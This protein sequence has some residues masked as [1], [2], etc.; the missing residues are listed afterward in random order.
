MR[1]RRWTTVAARG[2]GHAAARHAQAITPT[3]SAASRIDIAPPSE[4]TAIPARRSR[5]IT[6][7]ASRAPSVAGSRARSIGEKSG[8]APL[9]RK[10]A[11]RWTTSA[12]GRR[13]ASADSVAPGPVNVTTCVGIARRQWP[14]LLVRASRHHGC[15]QAGA[16]SQSPPRRPLELRRCGDGRS[17]VRDCIRSGL[18]LVG[19][20][21]NRAVTEGA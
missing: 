20:V 3:S 7:R 17:T 10:G 5:F 14:S 4:S 19:G 6:S 16:S 18:A 11:A 9:T 2:C 21:R 13:S 8:L 12:A 15:V 1:A